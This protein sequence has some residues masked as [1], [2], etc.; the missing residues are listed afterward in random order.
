MKGNP[1]QII[2]G[3]LLILLV[4]GLIILAKYLIPEGHFPFLKDY[5]THILPN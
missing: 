5:F 1:W 4:G 2:L 3:S